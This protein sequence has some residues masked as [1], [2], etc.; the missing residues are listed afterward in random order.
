MRATGD[1]VG[2]FLEGGTI[3]R[4]S[5]MAFPYAQAT[6]AQGVAGRDGLPRFEGPSIVGL[7]PQ[8]I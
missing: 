6:A 2:S 1:I 5:L 3:E 7:G 8:S 4:V